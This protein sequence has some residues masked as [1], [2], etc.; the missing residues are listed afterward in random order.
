[1]M[2]KYLLFAL[3]FALLHPGC[4]DKKQ[5]EMLAQQN[6]DL[7]E[8]IRTLKQEVGKLGFLASRMAGIKARIETN[9]GDIE[10]RLFPERAPIHCFA[11]LARAEG[12]FY[13]NTQFHRV[14]PGF[15]IQGGDPNTK[16]SDPAND[17]FGGP[18]VAIPH[19]F[20]KVRHI[21]GVLSMARTPDKSAGAGSQFFIMHGRNPDLDGEYTAFGEVTGGMDVVDKIANVEIHPRLNNHPL[22]PVVIKTIQAFR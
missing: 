16:D 2:K 19:E 6:S 3:V 15:M 1:M 5:M 17:G 7:K 18:L 9:L 22:K 10:L 20:N 13:D 4:G 11:F 8:E 21:R 12:G 14:I